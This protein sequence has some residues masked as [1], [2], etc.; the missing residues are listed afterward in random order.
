MNKDLLILA[1]GVGRRF[2]GLK[3]LAPVGPQGE[4]I[5]DYTVHDAVAAGF[6]RVVLVIRRS[7]EEPI[8]AHVADGFGRHVEVVYAFQDEDPASSARQKPWGTTHAVLAARDLL[9]ERFAVANADDLYGRHALA[10]VGQFLD[11]TSTTESP[12]W[13]LVGYRAAATLPPEGAVS[14]SVLRDEDGML[15]SIDEIGAMSRHPNGACWEGEEGLVTVPGDTLVSMNLWAFT[16]AIHRRFEECFGRFRAGDPGSDDEILL[17]VT[18][19]EL[20]AR[21]QARVRLLATTSRWCG[22]TAASDRTWVQ[23]RIAERVAE[24]DYPSPLWR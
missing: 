20:I 23:E 12:T 7:I 21:R 15:S 6:E 2:G 24:G 5:M 22:I 3:Q 16:S 10:T 1:A 8:R 14:R 18:I 9:G 19:G 17:P 11:H 13:A 4:A